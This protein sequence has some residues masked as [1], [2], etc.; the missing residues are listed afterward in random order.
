MNPAGSPSW[1][2]VPGVMLRIRSLLNCLPRKKGFLVYRVSSRLIFPA[3]GVLSARGLGTVLRGGGNAPFSGIDLQE[4][5][6]AI[7]LANAGR[8]ARSR[9]GLCHKVTDASASF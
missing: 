8:E 9:D 1:D 3:S 2:K 4:D 7:R 6:C 5:D